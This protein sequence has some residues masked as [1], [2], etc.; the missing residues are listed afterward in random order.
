MRAVLRFALPALLILVLA[1]WIGGL[2]GDLVADSGTYRVETSMPAAVLLLAVIATLATVIL[3]F[4]GAVRRSPQRVLGWRRA[5]RQ[6]QGE[7]A[8]HRGIAALSVGDGAQAAIQGKRAQVFL[9]DTP[10]V[11]LL[12]AEAARL[13]GDHATAVQN[14]ERLSAD[15]HLGFAGQHGLLRHSLA[16]A[17][18]ETAERHAETA[19]QKYPGSQ[20]VA[21]QRLHLA[22]AQK[23]YAKALVFA[24]APAEVA[25]L[26]VAA[27]V[28][29]EPREATALA[30]RALR[31]RPGFAPAAAAY[32]ESLRKRGKARAASRALLDSWKAAPHPLI[33][34]TY[35]AGFATPL[36]RAKAAGDLAPGAETELV[37]A[38][39]ALAANLPG[40]AR[41]HA[42]A[43]MAAGLS[44]ARPRAV[45][46][47]LDGTAAPVGPVPGWRCEA[48]QA[49]SVDWAPVCPHCHKLGTLDWV[50]AGTQLTV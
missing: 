29:A 27:S 34:A 42:E 13:A 10:L 45:L 39:T 1:W 35:L 28:T 40:E 43:A 26:A 30:Q 48:C 17:D 18:H 49:E 21:Q 25:A 50:S 12:L 32:A 11:L 33:A 7:L 19:A 14:F 4:I 41:R 8:L 38:Q 5:R 47:A 37:L 3:R 44:D 9:G 31:A 16:A 22:V 2:P 24:R 20:W 6:K 36:E 46:A 15:E 23:H